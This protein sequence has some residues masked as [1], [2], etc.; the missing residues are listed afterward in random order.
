MSEISSSPA[1]GMLAQSIDKMPWWVQVLLFVGSTFGV[2]TAIVMFYLAQAAG[3]VPN[4]V[5]EGMDTL[6]G[7]VQELK[8]LSLRHEETTRHMGETIRTEIEKRKKRCVMRART[9]QE[10]EA[11]FVQ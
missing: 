6:Q 1:S 11:C 10:K 8:G 5:I 9:P 7:E 3:W 2:P 4:P